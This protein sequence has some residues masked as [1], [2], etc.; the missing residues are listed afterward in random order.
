MGAITSGIGALVSAANFLMPL[1][2]ANDQS[3]EIALQNRQLQQNA[4]IQK[5]KNLLALEQKESERLSKLR[6]AI[7]SQRAAL[8]GRGIS[9][10]GGSADAVLKGLSEDS[11][12]E[13]QSNIF[14]TQLENAKIDAGLGNSTQLNLLQKQQLKQKT[15]L[16]YL[17]DVFAS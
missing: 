16:G 4:E 15:T 10:V 11:E 2:S 14:A 8:A 7:S 1:K 9:P 13:S 12:A 6:K 5:Q 17:N 3:K